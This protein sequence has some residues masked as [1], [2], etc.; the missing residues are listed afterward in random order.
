MSED[1]EKF[2]GRW[3]HIQSSLL[4]WLREELDPLTAKLEQLI[5]ILD[6]LGLEAYV[7]A[8]PGG[9]GRPP[10][11]RRALARAFI[12]K[13]VLN[14]A[15]T[16]ALR[17]RLIIDRALRRICGWESKRDVPS[18]ATF[19]RGFAE[20]AADRTLERLHADLVKHH[21]GHRLIGHLA[22]DASEIPAREKPKRKPP[23]DPPPPAP[24]RTRGRPKKGEP[25]PPPEPKTRLERQR[26]QTLDQMIA[27]LPRDCDVGVKRNS[28]G[29][30]E[31]WIGYK[32]HLD[33][34][35]GHLPIAGLVTAASLHDSQAAIP[36]ATIS[37]SRVTNCYDLMD[38]A[39]DAKLIVDDSL[40]RGHIPIIDFNSRGCTEAKAE[41]QAERARR[42]L[43]NL[44]DPDD[45]LYNA[46]TLAER[47]FARLKD[48]FGAL[49]LR[50]RGNL[51]VTC[52]LMCGILALF[53]DQLMRIARPPPAPA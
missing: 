22:R 45:L 34:A 11:D 50:V 42:A 14:L 25:R 21:L 7:A 4:P 16:T 46:R 26:A 8:P 31:C 33:V 41:R 6:T 15:S 47:A 30:Q 27:E 32:L 38:A 37:A 36:L 51:K 29:H 5:I 44:P 19:S 9:R 1:R 2:A 13:T 12:A 17:E 49:N 48:E 10:A 24:A 40:D 3:S 35:D 53:A 20:L 18:E 52:H 43:I 23:S 39:Y 28:K